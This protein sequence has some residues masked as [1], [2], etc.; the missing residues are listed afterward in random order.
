M[1][2]ATVLFSASDIPGLQWL[3][4][5]LDASVLPTVCFLCG[6][7]AVFPTVANSLQVHFIGLLKSILPF[8]WLSIF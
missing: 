3:A 6:L 5:C 4:S 2:E 8:N 1:L 7:L